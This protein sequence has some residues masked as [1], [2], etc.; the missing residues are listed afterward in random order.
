MKKGGKLEEDQASLS[1][2]IQD[3]RHVY[4]Q[5]VYYVCDRQG[6]RGAKKAKER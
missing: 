1:Q 4:L 5:T 2:A 6:T 3:Y